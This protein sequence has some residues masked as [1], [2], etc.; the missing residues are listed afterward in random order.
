MS[1]DYPGA[2]WDEVPKYGYPRLTHGQ[3]RPRYV[4]IH[5][6]AGGTSAA[7]IG[8]Y[9]RLTD[10]ATSA[11]FCIGTAG[12]IHQFVRVADAAW[13]NGIVESGHAAWWVNNP[14]LYTISIEHCKA[15]AD[16]SNA[17]TAAQ[18]AASFALVRWLCATYHIPARQADA[19]GGIAPHSSIAPVSRARCPGPYPWSQLY[20]YLNGSPGGGGSMV[21]TGWHDD[22]AILTAP[23]GHTV[24]HGFRDFV[25]KQSW[26]GEN[27]PLEQEHAVAGGSAQL[28]TQNGL[29]YSAA[30]NQVSFD[31]I[32]AQLQTA[33]Q[34]S[35]PRYQQALQHVKDIVDGVL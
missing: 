5:G 34:S 24:I 2:V 27:V 3:N 7:A 4:I 14:N 9:Y 32:G 1:A 10:R 20:A 6:T 18:Q 17:L 22:G 23:N 21:P 13:G 15:S 33:R 31:S 16:N 12:E 11:H 8:N 19:A 26:P 29:L 25:L 35:D 30:S 28:F